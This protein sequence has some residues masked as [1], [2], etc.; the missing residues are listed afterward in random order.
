MT[1]LEET[2]LA[3]VKMLRSENAALSRVLGNPLERPGGGLEG[4]QGVHYVSRFGYRSGARS[5]SATRSGWPAGC[6]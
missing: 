3:E 5:T 2:L 6:C 4:L 1:I